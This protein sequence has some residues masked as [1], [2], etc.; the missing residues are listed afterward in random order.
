M[1]RND[2]RQ[3]LQALIDYLEAGNPAADAAAKAIIESDFEHRDTWRAELTKLRQGAEWT[4]LRA[5]EADLL[6]TALRLLQRETAD[7]DR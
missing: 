4:G 5:P 7:L 6:V 2:A 1:K 3:L